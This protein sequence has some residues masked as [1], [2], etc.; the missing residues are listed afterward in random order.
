MLIS[1]THATDKSIIS[2]DCA[3]QYNNISTFSL[4]DI[5]ECHVA[6]NPKVYVEKTKIALVQLNDYAKVHVKLCKVEVTREI[7]YCDAAW[8]KRTRISGAEGGKISYI[9]Y[10]VTL[11]IIL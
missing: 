10:N 1:D 2:F 6:M 11:C 4:I 9:G 7:A 5:G 8:Y 3:Q